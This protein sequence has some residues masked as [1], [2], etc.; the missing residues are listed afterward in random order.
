MI[1][2]AGGLSAVGA[3]SV[4]SSGDSHHRPPNPI[5]G[6]ILVI[7]AQ[8]IVA[9][10]MVLSLLF[11]SHS[12][13]F[14][15]VVEDKFVS[16]Y[17]VPPLLVVGWEGSW[18]F[19]I[20]SI[21]L[22]IFYFIP[23][24]PGIPGS[25]LLHF[26]SVPDALVQMSHNPALTGF[27]IGNLFSIAC[28]NFFGI[29]ITKYMTATTRTVLDSAR[30]VVIW[31]FF[32]AMGQQKFHYLQLIGFSMLIFGMLL[33]NRIIPINCYPF[34]PRSELKEEVKEPLLSQ[35]DQDLEQ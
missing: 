30:A 21:F 18:G 35:D 32:I 31:V 14:L 1:I 13:S 3:A 24:V 4:L 2:I 10:Q 22:V 16:K 28:F 11:I 34:V 33:Y 27:L 5:L 12:V 9:V 6:D 29:S 23:G 19:L 26:E 7:A 17:N 8:L 15:Q 20:L 25:D